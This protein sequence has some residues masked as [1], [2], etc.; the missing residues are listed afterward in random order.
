MSST[1]SSLDEAPISRKEEWDAERFGDDDPNAEG[2]RLTWKQDKAI[3]AADGEV[4]VHI[5]R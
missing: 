3:T 2:D 4:A 5:D 1:R